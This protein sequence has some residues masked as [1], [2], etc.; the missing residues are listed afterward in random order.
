MRSCCDRRAS[1]SLSAPAPS[2]PQQQ[3]VQKPQRTCVASCSVLRYVP[4]GPAKAG[5]YVLIREFA[6]SPNHQLPRSL[7]WIGIHSQRLGICLAADGQPNSVAA[8]RD[9]REATASATA[10][11]TAPSSAAAAA[12]AARRRIGT[13]VPHETMHDRGGR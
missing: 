5:H 9:R 8:R 4:P 11:A 10:A 12:A 7:P 1:S 13:E 2:K 6:N 3:R